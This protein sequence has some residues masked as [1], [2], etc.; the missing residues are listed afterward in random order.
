MLQQYLN[1]A[2][3]FYETTG[4]EGNVLYLG[5]TEWAKLRMLSAYSATI[6]IKPTESGGWKIDG[7]RVVG[8]MRD[9]WLEVGYVE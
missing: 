6:D 1:K 9:H 8:V 3:K 4:K 2:A 7:K 5:H